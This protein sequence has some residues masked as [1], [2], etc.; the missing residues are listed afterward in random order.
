MSFKQCFNEISCCH[1]DDT[2]KEKKL[3]Q[4]FGQK[5]QSQK[6]ENQ[7]LKPEDYLKKFCTIKKSVNG[8]TN[9]PPLEA[10]EKEMS[11][12]LLMNGS[13]DILC[14]KNQENNEKRSFSNKLAESASP[15]RPIK[16][17]HSQEEEKESQN[18]P[19]ISERLNHI[20][21]NLMP[22]SN[23]LIATLPKPHHA[24]DPLVPSSNS[25]APQSSSDKNSLRLKSSEDSILQC[26][27]PKLKGAE[28]IREKALANHYLPDFIVVNS[29]RRVEKQKR[30][31][32]E[33]KRK[34]KK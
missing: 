14:E 1:W 11:Q 27:T 19:S 7:S 12:K 5:E 10:S 33:I 25:F 22:P 28:V 9:S 31:L 29:I 17:S 21:S 18:C 26:L 13:I 24:D 34:N 30:K 4:I 32:P 20:T 23:R 15:E 2:A 3:E 8:S 16:D 6:E